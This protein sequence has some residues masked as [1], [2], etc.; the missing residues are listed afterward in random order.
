MDNVNANQRSQVMIMKDFIENYQS[1]EFESIL[2]DEFEQLKYLTNEI[3][4][5][6]TKTTMEGERDCNRKKNRY[7]DILPYDESRVCLNPSISDGDSK[8]GQCSDYINASFVHS[9]LDGHY[10]YIASQGPNKETCLD[11]IKMLY[12]YNIKLVVCACN[13]YEGQKLKCHRY[14]TDKVSEA[15]NFHKNYYVTLK[16]KPVT[17]DGCVVRDLVVKYNN[18]SSMSE[19]SSNSS[20]DFSDLN[21]FEFTQFHI[22]NWPDHGVPDNVESIMRMLGV[23]RARMHEN[24]KK[25]NESL[26]IKNYEVSKSCGVKKRFNKIPLS[27]EYL[28]VHCSAGCGRTG[29]IIA[30]DQ[31]WTLLN[32]NVRDISTVANLPCGFLDSKVTRFFY[33][34]S[35]K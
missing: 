11:F 15:F 25:L 29:T 32:E 2:Y 10:K 26:F 28:A 27:S 13:E 31:V 3:R 6:K 19:S 22:T 8:S 9:A 5:Y 1:P 18:P 16:S 30:I 21:E 33:V 14:W 17:L 7:R 4:H 34:S 12:Q 35:K 24:N 20:F 23:V